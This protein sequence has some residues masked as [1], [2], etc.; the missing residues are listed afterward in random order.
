MKA[1]SLG[2]TEHSRIICGDAADVLRTFSAD[3]VNLTVTSPP[4]Y[5]HRDYGVAGQ[6]G[7]E[8][9]LDLY[10]S[11][12]REVLGELL[13]VTHQHGSCFVVV[14]D[15]YLNGKLLLVPHR[16][17]LAAADL[18]WTIRNDVIWQKTCP[19]PES[20]RNRWRAGHEHILFLSKKKSGYRFNADAIRVPYAP[21]TLRRWGGGQVY[22]GQK[23][24]GRTN[25]ND[26]RM[27]DGKSFRLDPL[28][29]LPTDV[30]SL[31]SSNTAAKHYAAFPSELVRRI[32]EACSSPGDLI[33]DPFLGSGTTCAVA[34]A[35]GRRSVG[36]ELNAEYA[37]LAAA[38]V[39]K[40]DA[41]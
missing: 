12:L 17:A 23:S 11:R 32:I 28:G 4:Y 31:P 27:R 36:I 5:R 37:E 20:P 9:T 6:I 1:K 13:R 40:N 29:C 15:T 19:P 3:V 14:G 2:E 8:A 10:L 41:A 35:L 38:A 39:G 25:A 30:W 21:A 7:K 34:R 16:V 24:K 26:S 22:G 18:G 33:L